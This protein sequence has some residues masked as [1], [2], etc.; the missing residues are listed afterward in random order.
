VPFSKI[1]RGVAIAVLA[2]SL[3]HR[4]QRAIVDAADV[5]QVVLVAV[6]LE[7][8]QH[9]AGVLQHGANVPSVLDAEVVGH[10][11]SLMD[12]DDGL[13]LGLFEIGLEPI[14]LFLR[15]ARVGPLEVL[16]PIRLPVLSEASV[17]NDEM[18]AAHIE[19]VVRLLLANLAEELLL[20]QRINAVV[21]Q[22]VMLLAGKLSKFL[23][24][25]C[26]ERPLGLDRFR[27]VDEVAQADHEVRLVLA[28]L[29][30]GVSQLGQALPVIP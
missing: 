8:G 24:D 22:D 7:H 21:A 14:N 16:A 27:R 23:V 26:Q 1:H 3:H 2:R 9:L 19:R 4:H 6:A 18:E 17:K 20:G 13:A 30:S 12:E 10:V 15:N 11:E 25:A 29:F 28:E 5:L